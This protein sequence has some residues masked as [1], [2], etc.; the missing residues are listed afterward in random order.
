MES[1]SSADPGQPKKET[2]GASHDGNNKPAGKSRAGVYAG[3]VAQR[4]LYGPSRCRG[5]SPRKPVAVSVTGSGK[6]PS[7]LSKMSDSAEAT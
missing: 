1:S 3:A 6:P 2:T 7:R 5:G 4:V